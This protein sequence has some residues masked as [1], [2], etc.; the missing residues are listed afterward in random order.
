MTLHIIIY[1]QTLLI[2]T[3]LF[4]STAWV[5]RFFTKSVFGNYFDQFVFTNQILCICYVQIIDLRNS[6]RIARSVARFTVHQTPSHPYHI[7]PQ[8]SNSEAPFSN[9]RM[10]LFSFFVYFFR[11]DMRLN[12]HTRLSAKNTT[13]PI[14]DLYKSKLLGARTCFEH[15]LPILVH[16]P[17]PAAGCGRPNVGRRVHRLALREEPTHQTVQRGTRPGRDARFGIIPVG[18]SAHHLG[19]A[20]SVARV[21]QSSAGQPNGNANG[22]R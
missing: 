13:K 6:F 15:R 5:F 1:D 9:H 16:R 3:R 19:S 8:S 7:R 10:T 20:A 12:P 2:H 21:H 18:R 22:H 4:K 17:S 11:R 14:S